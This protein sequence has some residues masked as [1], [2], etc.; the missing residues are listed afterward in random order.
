MAQKQAD[1]SNVTN[2]AEPQPQDANAASAAAET[3]APRESDQQ[4]L[5]QTVAGGRYQVGEQFVDANGNP[6]E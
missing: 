1:Q 6:I 2:S 5:D 3:A 4:R